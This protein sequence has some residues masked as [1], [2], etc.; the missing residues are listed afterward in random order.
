MASFAADRHRYRWPLLVD[1]C[2]AAKPL[3][4]IDSLFTR[5]SAVCVTGLVAVHD[6]LID[7]ITIPDSTRPLLP[8]DTLLTVGAPDRLE[9]ITR[10]R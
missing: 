8:S 10:L 4:V 5:T 2:H 7:S 6:S 9:A 1:G 3:G